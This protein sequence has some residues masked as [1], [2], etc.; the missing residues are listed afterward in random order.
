MAHCGTSRREF[1]VLLL[2][3]PAVRAQKPF[4][5]ELWASVQSIYARTLEHPFLK[6][7]A[8]GT[9][10]RSRFEFY[11][12]Q[13]E[14]Y[15]R[16]FAQALSILA[17][18]APRE[19]WAMT[20][21]QHAASAIQAERELH[22]SIL[23]AFGVPAQKVRATD[24]APTNVAYTNHLLAAAH[25][26]SFGEGLA[27]VLPC[28]WIYWEVGKELKKRG[29]KDPH[30]QR[31]IEMYSGEEYGKVVRQVLD[32]MNTESGRMTPEARRAAAR[33][34]EISSRYEWMFWD[35]AWREEAWPP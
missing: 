12:I 28:Y 4:T 5:G 13:D 2:A 33:L 31:W 22:D 35:M 27:A 10:P 20:L 21:N 9:L 8:D 3:A 29:S 1:L 14:L 7:L 23:Q 17:S 15:L 24:M 11:L 18:K 19:E 32:M 34:F 6:E 26:R 25:Q 16:A 30:Y